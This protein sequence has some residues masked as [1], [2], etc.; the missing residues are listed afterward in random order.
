MINKIKNNSLLIAT[1][2]DGTLLDE[3]Y[4]I[5]PALDSLKWLK[6]LGIPII[7]CTSKT[8]A[9]VQKFRRQYS[10]CDP[11]IVEN[12]AA[13]YGLNE[14]KLGASHIN[15]GKGHSE[16][17]PLLD[18]L[19][20]AIGHEL[21][22]FE[23]LSR[24]AI[25]KLTGLKSDDIDLAVKRLWSVP[26]LNPSAEYLQRLNHI[27]RELDLTIVQG[28]RMSHLL[29]KNC[30]KGNAINKL[31]KIIKDPNIL[32]IG[33]GDS[34]NDYSLLKTADI[35][36]VVPGSNGPH[37]CFINEIRDGRFILAPAPHAEGWSK[38]V[39]KVVNNKLLETKS[40]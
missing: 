15:L 35:S 36:I 38:A 20:E 2:L 8:A 37:K 24:T 26:F 5:V 33:L 39:T 9:E 31:K 3:N 28:N 1:D 40:I 34:P 11:Y 32:V 16:L 13:I 10:L 25:K 6:N 29:D 21:I 14:Y 23:D 22:A 17:R 18:K 12:G 27:A 7:P 4:N 19:S 30:S